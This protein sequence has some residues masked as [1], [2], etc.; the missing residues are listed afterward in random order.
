MTQTT[1]FDSPKA[2]HSDPLTSQLSA[3][4]IRSSLARIKQAVCDVVNASQDSLTANEVAEIAVLRVGVTNNRESVRK[5]V[6]EC[7]R[8]GLIDLAE[9]RL[10]SV[11]RKKCQAFKRKTI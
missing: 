6:S 9:V 10:C 1:F 5:R 8:A 11:S 2:R 7:Y 3:A 4:D